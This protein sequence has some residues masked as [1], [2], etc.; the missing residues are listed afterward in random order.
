MKPW[1][2]G[3][4]AEAGA[5]AGADAGVGVGVGAA[6]RTQVK[7]SLEAVRCEANVLQAIV[8]ATYDY[9]FV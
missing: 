7:G 4:G 5:G 3:A 9:L 1:C 2:A 8:G 6:E